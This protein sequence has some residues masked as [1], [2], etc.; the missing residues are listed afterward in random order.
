MIANTPEE[1]PAEEKTATKIAPVLVVT[2]ED[3]VP[4]R[5]AVDLRTVPALVLVA[6]L[7]PK[8][9]IPVATTNGLPAPSVVLVPLPIH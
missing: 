5:P 6:A 9:V 4:V 3:V 2:A 8:L 1:P 7:P